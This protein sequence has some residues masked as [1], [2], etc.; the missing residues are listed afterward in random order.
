MD[1]VLDEH[2][3]RV[4]GSLLEKEITTPDQYPLSLNALTNACNQKSNRD[5]VMR[6][7]EAQVLAALDSLRGKHLILEKSGFGSRVPKYQ[8]R[9]CNT[10]FGTLQFSEQ[11]F[12]LVC[13]LLLRGP[14]TPGELRSRTQRLCRFSDVG[15]VEACLEALADRDDGPFVVRLAREPGKRESR[16][17]H[18]FSGEVQSGAAATSAAADPDHSPSLGARV[19]RL[20]Q[21]VADLAEQLGRLRKSLGED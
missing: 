9:F 2:E 20:E 19:Y 5:P 15:E 1:L 21:Q 3:A 7:D 13:V 17:A 10:Q 18:L 12:G 4:V 14:Q 16:Y 6:L 11:E 8:H